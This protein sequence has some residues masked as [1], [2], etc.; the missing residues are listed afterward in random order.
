MAAVVNLP[1]L[2]DHCKENNKCAG[3]F[4]TDSNMP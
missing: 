3:G 4:G 1:K 2:S